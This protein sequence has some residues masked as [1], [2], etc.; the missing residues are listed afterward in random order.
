MQIDNRKLERQQLGVDRWFNSSVNGSTKNCQGTLYYYT[1]VGKTY[2][3]ILI[4]KRLLRLNPIHSIVVVVPANVYKQWQTG[5]SKNLTKQQLK[6]INVYTPNYIVNNDIRI[7]T[8][9]LIVDELHECYSSEFVK[10]I[11]GEYIRAENHLGLT[12]TYEDSKGRH[13]LIK[14]LYPVIDTITEEEAIREGYVAPFVEFNLSVTLT[15]KEQ[16]AYEEY[17]KIINEN[18]NK[19]PQGVNLEFA[20]KCLS[21]G[22]ING[23]LYTSAQIVYGYAANKGWRKDMDLSI[24]ANE[25]INNLWNPHK[26]YG[27]AV[28]LLNAIRFRKNLLYN[29]EKKIELCMQ[30]CERYK[31]LKGIIFSQSTAFADKLNLLL[32]EAEPNSSVVYHSNLQT[33]FLPSPKTGK[34]IKHGKT[35]L[36]KIALDTFKQGTSVK[37]CTA[38]SLDK[39][40]DDTKIL[41]AITASG[42]SNFTQYKQ[43]G[44][45]AKRKDLFN[46]DKVALLINL[47][48]KDSKEEDWLKKRQSKTNHLIHWIDDINEISFNPQTYNDIDMNEV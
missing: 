15:E 21:G 2:T 19:F 25:Q 10:V 1:G 24:P 9:T 32:N 5:L 23:K 12:A 41:L 44:G 26:I 37:M 38:S 46:E 4:I 33:V 35:R 36:K 14:D 18:L 16:E 42:T 8:G 40:F 39:G 34:L 31:D 48:V 45:R 17:T 29:S 11:N 30:I 28:A 22:T 20:N 7:Q 47:Y 6:V 27:Y 43:R 13:N 3:T